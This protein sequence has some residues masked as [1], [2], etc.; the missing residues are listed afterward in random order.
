ML[1]YYLFHSATPHFGGDDYSF[2]VIK[3]IVIY[4]LPVLA[5]EK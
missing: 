5:F 2:G 1:I 4:F 3:C